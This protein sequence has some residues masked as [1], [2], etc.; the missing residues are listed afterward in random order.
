MYYVTSYN[1]KEN[2][3]SEYQQ[4]LQSDE[5]KELFTAVEQETGW[6]YIETYWAIMGFGDYDCEDWWEVP[7]WSN[8]DTIRGSEASDRLFARFNELNFS[9]SSGPSSTRMLR[10]NSDVRVVG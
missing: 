6:R 7:D 2:K 5:A 1:L 9:D 8:F 3:A 10:T 4:W